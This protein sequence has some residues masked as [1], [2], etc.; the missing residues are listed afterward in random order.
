MIQ[1]QINPVEKDEAS[2]GLATEDNIDSQLFKF[3]KH[4]YLEQNE[5]YNTEDRIVSRCI[6]VTRRGT[7]TYPI[8]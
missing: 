6:Q 3:R 8:V 4:N 2:V 1:I 5:I 7:K